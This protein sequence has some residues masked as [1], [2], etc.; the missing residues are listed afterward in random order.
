[1]RHVEIRNK[2]LDF[3][4]AKDHT[5]VPSDS[6]VPAGDPTLL[7]T[8][9]GMTQFKSEFMGNVKGF[10]RAASCQKCMRTGDLENVGKTA[11]HHTF[12]EMLG[13]FSFG[14]YF[15][16]EAITWAWEFL[17]DTLKIPEKRLW[18]S[19]YDKDDEAYG[20]WRDK[21]R[22]PEK[23][24]IRFG[25][26][27]NFWPSEAKI[28]GPNGPCGPCSEIFYDYGKS[29]GCGK[30]GCSP[31]CSCGRF[32]ELWNLVFTQF[33]RKENGILEPLPNKSIDTGMGLER[34]CAVMQGVR[35]NFETD[36]FSDIIKTIKDMMDSPAEKKNN[37]DIYV[38]ADHIRAVIFAIADGVAPSNEERGYV[39]RNLIRKAMMRT[40]N[41]GIQKPSLYKLVYAVA[42]TMQEP[43]PEVIKEHQDIAAVI[44]TEEERFQKTLEN[45]IPMVEEAVCML[46]DSGVKEMPG[47]IAFELYDTHGIPLEIIKETAAAQGTNVDEA[48]FNSL[49]QKQREA[50]RRSSKMQ[51]GIFTTGL[52]RVKTEFIGYNKFESFAS[53]IEMM[54]KN[55]NLIKEANAGTGI[56]EIILDKS[57]FYGESGGQVG[58]K[59]RISN[60]GTEILIQRSGK[61]QDAI[62][63]M[64]KIEKGG[65]RVG[66]KVK[67][68]IDADYRMAI[69]RNH[70]AAHLLQEALRRVLGEHVKQQ[71][72]L[73]AADRLRFDFAHSKALTDDELE[74][75]EELVNE[76]IK[77][78]HD[79]KVK[80]MSL[81]DARS[82]GALAFFGDKYEQRVRVVRAGTGSREL[83][84]GTHLNNTAEIEFFKITH[85]G[86]VA[87][88]IRRV[89]ACTADRARKWEKE[90]QKRQGD[91]ESILRKK[92]EEKLLEKKKLKESEQAAGVIMKKSRDINGIK[93]IIKC[94]NNQNMSVLKY[95]SDIIRNKLKQEYLLFFVS[96]QQGKTGTLLSLS[97]GLIEKGFNAPMLLSEIIKPF[98]GKAGGRP[99]MAQGG[100]KELKDTE[101][102]L[103]TAEK[104]LV[105]ELG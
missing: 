90:Y 70:T 58:D 84:G 38:I 3:F 95:I 28:K 57:V 72:S 62:V 5:L 67:A 37:S 80:E 18:A 45:G 71:G 74:R 43:Y 98:A 99:N 92:R 9:A 36:I 33:E 31:I 68:E 15:K 55:G 23:R 64:G 30:E 79:V 11:Y 34:L 91:K 66:D 100:I 7:F 22:M 52:I 75:V 54:D 85:E 77:A 50:S 82:S 97:N 16:D 102:L 46:R 47:D 94:M 73:V 101:E 32:V 51:A 17:K 78:G 39:I 61:I 21:I 4:K 26:K 81:K 59:G 10:T 48:G 20:I 76:N 14:G 19:V 86:S 63:L 27:D 49:M 96:L 104:I 105:K 35:S 12:F 65:I 93:L 44:K 69:A 13:N 56:V 88:G 6:L 42:K 2:F 25:Q 41:L 29:T 24:I 89:E 40:K 83:C 103:K 60:D 8:S 87:S 1:M 53:V